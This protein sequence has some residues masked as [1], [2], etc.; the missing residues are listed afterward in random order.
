MNVVLVIK[1]SCLEI[2]RSSRSIDHWV[3]KIRYLAFKAFW[4]YISIPM[5]QIDFCLYVAGGHIYCFTFRKLLT[6]LFLG[7]FQYTPWM[8]LLGVNNLNTWRKIISETNIGFHSVLNSFYCQLY[9]NGSLWKTVSN[10]NQH[11]D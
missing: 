2:N 9:S 11:Q 5:W 6:S 7:P 8:S 1:Q 4:A 10:H 3:Q